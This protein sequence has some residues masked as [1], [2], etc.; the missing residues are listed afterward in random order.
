[1]WQN[2]EVS[3]GVCTLVVSLLLYTL[4]NKQLQNKMEHMFYANQKSS[5]TYNYTPQPHLMQAT[6]TTIYLPEGI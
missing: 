4:E 3:V 5:L 2:S 1:M 6:S